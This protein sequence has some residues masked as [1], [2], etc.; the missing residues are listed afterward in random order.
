MCMQTSQ[1]KKLPIAEDAQFK[2]WVEKEDL[3]RS[4]IEKYFQQP[5]RDSVPAQNYTGQAASSASAA[6]SHR[7][8]S[9]AGAEEEANP[10]GRKRDQPG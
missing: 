4:E 10:R 9:W 5:T 3:R 1:A 2:F 6:W 8:G 7:Y